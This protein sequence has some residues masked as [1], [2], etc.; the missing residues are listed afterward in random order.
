MPQHIE[1]LGHVVLVGGGLGVAPVFPQ[2]RAF[3]EAGNRVTA[4][5]A[6]ARGDLVFWEDKFAAEAD[7][8]IVCTDDGSRGRAGRVTAALAD[9]CALSPPT[10]PTWSSPSARW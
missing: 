2:L 3:R 9:L 10:G 5:S 8:V 1:K 6:S 4:V 7:E